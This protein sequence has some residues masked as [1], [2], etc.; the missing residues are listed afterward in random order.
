[1]Q[2]RHTLLNHSIELIGSAV[3]SDL[4]RCQIGQRGRMGAPHLA[5]RVGLP[6]LLYANQAVVNGAPQHWSPPLPV[7]QTT[8]RGCEGNLTLNL[9]ITNQ[10]LYQLSYAPL[11]LH[12]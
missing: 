6:E 4:H 10:L 7:Q 2:D 12:K 9:L 1:M 3:M 11:A 5:A 8:N